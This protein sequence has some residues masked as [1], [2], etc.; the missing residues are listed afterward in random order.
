LYRKGTAGRPR[1]SIA[2]IA[3]GGALIGDYFTNDIKTLEDL[4]IHGL[5]DI[6]CAEQQYR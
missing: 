5:Q 6:Y 2:I 4:L 3:K 1:R